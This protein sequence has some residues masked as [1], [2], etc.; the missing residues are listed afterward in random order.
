VGL[1]TLTPEEE[2]FAQAILSESS[3]SNAYQV[4]YDCKSMTSKEVNKKANKAAKEE[5]IIKR[6]QELRELQELEEERSAA[7]LTEKQE[8]FVNAYLKSGCWSDA[9]R[10]AYNTE[11]MKPATINRRAHDLSKNGKI[12]ARISKLKIRAL[13]ENRLTHEKIT[14][15]LV[16]IA[17]GTIKNLYDKHGKFIHPSEMNEEQAAIL[18]KYEESQILGDADT[19]A[20]LTKVET[21][22]V[23]KA[24]DM[25][26]RHVGYYEKDHEQ[27]SAM[28]KSWDELE[29]AHQDLMDEMRADRKRLADRGLLIEKALSQGL[30]IEDIDQ[31]AVEDGS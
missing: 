18:K 19:K 16:A 25:L 22:D 17:F 3:L 10:E 29:Q 1:K 27:A 13:E 12:K 23:L 21:N 15:R 8:R 28:T 6:I 2:I 14:Q 30:D 5:H 11:N 7:G 26:A 9:Y 20:V 31:L 4:A 24:M